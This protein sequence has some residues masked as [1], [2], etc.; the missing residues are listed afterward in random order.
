MT[1]VETGSLFRPSNFSHLTIW[2]GTLDYLM[3]SP[4]SKAKYW[5]SALISK[6]Q[7]LWRA[8]GAI[9]GERAPAPCS[10]ISVI[11]DYCTNIISLDAVIFFLLLRCV[12][13]CCTNW[14]RGKVDLQLCSLGIN[15]VSR[16]TN[17]QQSAPLYMWLCRLLLCPSICFNSVA[18]RQTLFFKITSIFIFNLFVLVISLCP[19]CLLVR[20]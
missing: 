4:E 10:R 2:I 14:W 17:L 19:F 5:G 11:W 7:V 9:S 15:C 18:Y 20:F 3:M 16:S 13:C 6:P 8:P 12:L 1:E